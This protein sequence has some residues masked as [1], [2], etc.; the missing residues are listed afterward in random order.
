[1]DISFII[2]FVAAFFWLFPAI[3]QYKTE[4]FLYF[5]ILALSDPIVFAL[6]YIKPL[7]GSYTN[8]ILTVYQAQAI[9][10]FILLPSLYRFPQEN[11][12]DKTI[13]FILFLFLVALFF[14]PAS[15]K[16][17]YSLIT[18]F[19]FMIFLFFAKRSVYFIAETS[20]VNI[21]HII[22]LLYDASIIL[23]IISIL[24]DVKFEGGS[25]QVFFFVTDIFQMFIAVFF[26]IFKENN[27]KL[28]IDLK[29]I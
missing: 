12:L 19:H 20:K 18:L 8:Y 17:Y 25:G 14:T 6:F 21:F 24:S 5:F 1:M 15:Q 28:W 13:I 27:N 9:L 10:T 26:T 7:L 29:K 22:L 23:K 16:I 3:R 2:M 4:L 11:K